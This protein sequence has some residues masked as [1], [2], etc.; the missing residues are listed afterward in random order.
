M[1]EVRAQLNYLRM[2]PRKVRLVTDVIKGMDYPSAK[3]T[4]ENLNKR[5]AEPVLKVLNSAAANGHNNFNL[6]KDNLYVK[7][8]LVDEGVK[9][10]R[11][12]PKGFGMAALIQKKTSHITLVLDEKVKGMVRQPD[13]EEEKVEEPEVTE[14]VQAEEKA[15]TPEAK[16]DLGRKG[17]LFGNLKRKMFRRKAI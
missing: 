10:K 11:Y 14:E 7:D 16:Q 15:K 12:R 3:V 4:L 17:G 13:K 1:A 2:A 9:M 6:V 8:V 5:A